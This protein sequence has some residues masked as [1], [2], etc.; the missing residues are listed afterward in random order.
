MD[1][2]LPKVGRTGSRRGYYVNSKEDKNVDS[3]FLKNDTSS[4]VDNSTA[5][6][7]TSLF[8]QG[9]YR[10]DVPSYFD[11]PRQRLGYRYLGGLT[12]LVSVGNT[13]LPLEQAESERDKIETSGQ[14]EGS[15]V[16]VMLEIASRELPEKVKAG[17]R[18]KL[19][20]DLVG[21]AERYRLKILHAIPSTIHSMIKFP[22]PKGIATLIARTIT[23]AECRKREEK[24]MIRTEEPQKAEGVMLRKEQII[25]NPSFPDQ[26][27]TIGGRLSKGCKEQLKTLLKSNMEVFAWE[28]AD[29]TGVPRKVIE[30]AL[31]VNPSLDPVCQKKRTFS[32]EKSGAVTKE[33]T[34]WVK[35]GI[36]RP[37]KYPTYI[38]NPVL[39]KKCD[40]LEMVHRLQT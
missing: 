38:S 14:K 16:E 3:R 39:V 7:A 9:Q 30:H 24:Q 8:F 13:L 23:I 17:L 40:G 31:N 29:M 18:E 34:E 15:S 19:E 12:H 32:P 25:V 20:T 6:Y 28:P 10:S 27:V 11:T 26:M 36:V 5:P 22:T 2:L 4:I 35:A 21:F 37:V 33:V 1:S